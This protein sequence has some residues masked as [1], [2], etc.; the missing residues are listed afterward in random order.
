MREEASVSV[1]RLRS[2]FRPQGRQLVV[3]VYVNSLKVDDYCFISMDGL[4]SILHYT[5]RCL[6]CNACLNVRADHSS[7]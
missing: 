3:M 2:L 7:A 6:S 4:T 1:K 5:N